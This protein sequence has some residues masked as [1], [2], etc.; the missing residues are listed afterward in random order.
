MSQYSAPL[1]DM[2]FVLFDVFKMEAF[3]QNTESL[4]EVVDADTA[5][6]IL[7]ESAKITG[8]LLAC[9]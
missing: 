4:A 2:Q 5:K 8:E 1:R 6:A 9:Y 7:E 3:W